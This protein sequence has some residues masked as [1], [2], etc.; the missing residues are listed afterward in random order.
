MKPQPSHEPAATAYRDGNARDVVIVGADRAGVARRFH[1]REGTVMN[2]VAMGV[3]AAQGLWVRRR[4]PRL[5]QAG[6]AATGLVGDDEG[7]VLRVAILGESTAAGLGV[8]SHAEGFPGGFA[9]E[10]AERAGRGVRWQVT[11]RDGATIR[12]V[13]HRMLD[14]VVDEHDCVVL[15]IGANDVLTRTPATRW[16]EDL[17]SVLDTL[18]W[19][20]G[21]V[22][23]PSVAPFE[24]FP[25][26][27]RTL[28]GY[29]ADKARALDEVARS[30]CDAR[31]GADWVDSSDGL[32]I[33]PEF[34]ASDG[35][36]PSAV[37]YARW[38]ARVAGC[39]RLT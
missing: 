20:A 22:L 16:A 8:D 21:Q 19:R 2:P 34:F 7:G 24:R 3:V 35:F 15:L 14:S 5:P 4:I 32:S 1:T 37:G 31:P 26:L 25:S 9:R 39:V 10:L 17:G 28:A 6:G 33:G 36:H 23:V 29:L 18:S 11:G 38:A 13:R 27:P 30:V 12:Y